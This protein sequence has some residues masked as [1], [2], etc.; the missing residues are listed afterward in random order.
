M[1]PGILL[2]RAN[3][4]TEPTGD[5]QCASIVVG[6]SA[7][8][9]RGAFKLGREK[10]LCVRECLVS[11]WGVPEGAALRTAGAGSRPQK[12][13]PNRPTAECGNP[14]LLAAAVAGAARLVTTVRTE[15]QQ[16]SPSKV[17]GARYPLA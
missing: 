13:P 14:A 8:F 1:M 2:M 15:R 5:K 12:L 17:S 4:S 11:K 3:S 16:R 10:M 7:W 6:E 9:A